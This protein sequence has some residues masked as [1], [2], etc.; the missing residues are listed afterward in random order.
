MEEFRQMKYVYNDIELALKM[1]TDIQELF[2]IEKIYYSH[3]IISLNSGKY[4][5]TFKVTAE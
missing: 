5:V 2:L 3:K 4:L 1:S